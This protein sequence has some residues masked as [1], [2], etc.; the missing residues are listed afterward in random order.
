[1]TSEVEQRQLPDST[2][3]LARAVTHAAL[4]DPSRAAP[5]VQVRTAALSPMSHERQPIGRPAARPGS[6]LLIRAARSLLYQAWRLRLSDPPAR[7]TAIAGSLTTAQR[8]RATTTLEQIIRGN[9]R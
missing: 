2:I 9:A 8:G 6:D 5:S 1:M 3:Y 7:L 4:Q